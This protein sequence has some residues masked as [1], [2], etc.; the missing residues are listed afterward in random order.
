MSD[1]RTDSMRRAQIKRSLAVHVHQQRAALLRRAAAAL[2][3]QP[4]R[5]GPRDVECLSALALH[6][7]AEAGR[8]LAAY[9]RNLPPEMKR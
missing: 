3:T 6:H 5:M 4:A 7:E 1:Y 8:A 2:A 9:E